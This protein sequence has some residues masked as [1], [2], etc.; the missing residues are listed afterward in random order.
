MN[1]FFIRILSLLATVLAVCCILSG[2]TACDKDTI[3]QNYNKVLQAGGEL[4][5][6][7]DA[8]LQGTRVPGGDG[9]TGS[10][11]A[12]YHDFSG[13]EILF[14]G[15]ALKRTAGDTVTVSCTLSGTG[16]HAKVLFRSGNDAPKTLLEDSG[17]FSETLTLPA[18]SNSIEIALTGYSGEFQIT[19]L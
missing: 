16:G 1:H 11:T 6:T 7:P 5:L 10:Y 8:A 12:A 15:T 17:A 19:V 9:Y 13:T 4:A 2:V 18:G 3:L 14:G